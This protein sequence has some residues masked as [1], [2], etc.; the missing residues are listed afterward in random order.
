MNRA[1]LPIVLAISA[2]LLT[3]HLRRGWI[4]HD[5]GGLGES[6]EWV[7]EGGLPHRD[8]DE[9]YTGGLTYLNAAA[10]KALGINLLA[11]RILLFAGFL[12][13]V[14]ALFGVARRF[15][16]HAGAAVF[17]LLGVVWSVPNYAVG[18]PSWYNLFLATFGTL[19][20]LFYMETARPR[21]LVAAGLC[22]GLSFLIK[23]AGLYYLAGALLF[24]VFHAHAH[25]RERL[26]PTQTAPVYRGFVAAG[27]G[28]FVAMLSYLIRARMGTAELVHFVLPGSL[29][30]AVVLAAEWRSPCGPSAARFAELF[31]LV[32]PF[33]LGATIPVALYLIPYA[34][35]H[36]LQAFVDGVFVLPAKR[37]SF[38]ARHPLPLVTA[39]AAVPLIALLA[40]IPRFTGPH[41]RR[42]AIELALIL[43]AVLATAPFFPGIYRTVWYGVRTLIPILVAIGAWL[44]LRGGP[45]EALAEN[46]QRVFL[47]LA[48]TAVTSLIQF[49]FSAPIYLL[50]VAP[51]AILSLAGLVGLR[52]PPS[53]IP[54]PALATFYLLFGLLWIN[55]GYVWQMGEHYVLDDQR[56]ELRL[57]RA[58]IEVSQEDRDTFERLVASV[59]EHARGDYIYATP[60]CPEVYFLS[61][62]KNPTH[63]LFDFFDDPEKRTTRVVSVLE[64]RGI[65]VVV[66]NHA[67]LF[68]RVIPLELEAAVKRLYPAAD[69]IGRFEVRWRP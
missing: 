42:E 17:T 22:G 38:A 41:R 8:F 9:L 51:L 4:A 60:D 12:L 3:A 49:P 64:E 34:R 48:I 32:I 50:Y 20:L 29:L 56:Y 7:L 40:G 27:L 28:L 46:R 19:A 1:W 63:T 58:H 35:A 25:S 67:S 43:V 69:T 11:P 6:A 39:W 33:L 45:T 10:F 54:V 66:F 37:L 65:N 36:A 62:L 30:A 55:T 15:A 57:P 16:S 52:P 44:L 68:T 13:W 59:Q 2:L 21:W 47:L 61:G 24:L 5:E 18:V 53:P 26:D 23:I 14:P 31:R